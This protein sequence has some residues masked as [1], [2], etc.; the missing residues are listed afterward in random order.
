[1]R[2][3]AALRLLL[4]PFALLAGGCDGSSS[5]L[6]SI[7]G[8][9][10]RPTA[11]VRQDAAGLLGDR[12]H[13]ADG[14]LLAAD[15]TAAS[16][17]PLGNTAFNRSGGPITVTKVAGTTGRYIATFSRLSSF[18]G[19]RNTVHITAHGM[20]PGAETAYCKP[21][22]ASLV[23]D[24][25]EV[26][27]FKAGTSAA[28]NAQFSLL[29]TRDYADLAFA[30][31]SQP[32]I[33]SYTA[34][35]SSWN[36]AG[37]TKVARSAVGQYLVTFNGL[38]GELPYLVGGHVQVNAVGTANA[39]CQVAAWG[40]SPNMAVRVGCFT[41]GGA[42]VDTKFTVLFLVPTDH[43]AYALIDQ[44]GY[45]DYFPNALYGTNPARSGGAFVSHSTAGIYT[46]TWREA[47]PAILGDGTVQVTAYGQKGEQCKVTKWDYQE[48]EV[49]C[50]TVKGVLTNSYFTVLLGS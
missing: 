26:R 12:A 19:S 34:T 3:T 32:T 46:V 50:F 2:A 41:A 44:L 23:A 13:W 43:L 21:V 37:A 28:V 8:D 15:P 45:G 29:V 17:T 24:K 48:V 20:P 33:A 39:H 31:A 38:G 30:Y 4:V 25:V 16:Y 9:E 14:Y 40:G 27:C 42:P 10:A 11:P 7:G 22:A 47:D 5:P 49:R 36:P 35:A 18:V 6:E 1:M